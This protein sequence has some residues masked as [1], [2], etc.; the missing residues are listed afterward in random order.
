MLPSVD[1]QNSL[2]CFFSGDWTY[3]PI[4]PYSVTDRENSDS[5]VTRLST[6][7]MGTHLDWVSSLF[8]I[9]WDMLAFWFIELFVVVNS[10]KY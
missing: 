10:F 5:S 2:L 7:L 4:W 1:L 8:T 6:F 3:T 9:Y